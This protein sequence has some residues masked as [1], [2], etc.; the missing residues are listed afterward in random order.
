VDE[1]KSP[2]KT[3][4]GRATR[5]KNKANPTALQL[6]ELTKRVPPIRRTRITSESLSICSLNMS[7]P[8][9]TVCVDSVSESTVYE[10]D[11]GGVVF[12]SAD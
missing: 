9:L 12:S 10:K 5:N 3:L 1:P 4:I 6:Q 7:E 11:S 2:A 8:S